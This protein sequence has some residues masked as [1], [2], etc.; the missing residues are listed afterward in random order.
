MNGVE[1]QIEDE[2]ERLGE[3]DRAPQSLAVSP[4]VCGRQHLHS[5]SC[6]AR[7]GQSTSSMRE[8]NGPEH[9]SKRMSIG[10]ARRV[11]GFPIASSMEPM[12]ARAQFIAPLAGVLIG[13]ATLVVIASTARCGEA[14]GGASEHKGRPGATSGRR[15]VAL[16]PT[17]A[18][19]LGICQRLWLVRPTCPRRVPV[20]YYRKARRPSGFGGL[21][22]DGAIALCSDSDIPITSR[23]CTSQ[24]WILEV[25]APAGLPPG[26]PPELGQEQLDPSRTRPPQYVHLIVYGARSNLDPIFP[27]A[28]PSRD[29][30]PIRDHLLRPK[31]TTPIFLGQHEWAGHN[32]TLVLAPPLVFGG[33]N[34]DHL[35]FRWR[36]KGT[37]HAVSLHSWA[38]LREAVAT[39]EATVASAVA[40]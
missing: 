25:G 14:S 13:L 24:T 8:R 36:E 7:W 4:Q 6:I 23:S 20:G 9:S 11:C 10:Q 18:A 16:R 27:F 31:R 1:V 29:R 38:P 22:A 40:G 19:A 3:L 17:P 21:S 30:R 2:D 35:I 39:L 32:G 15:E 34:G 37:D 26:A 12:S 33:E 5:Y 28:W